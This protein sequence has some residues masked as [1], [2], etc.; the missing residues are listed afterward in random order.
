MVMRMARDTEEGGR[1]SIGNNGGDD[2]E[3]DNV[4]KTNDAAAADDDDD[5]Y[6]HDGLCRCRLR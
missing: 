4:D 6:D 5:I 3:E 2:D 1:W